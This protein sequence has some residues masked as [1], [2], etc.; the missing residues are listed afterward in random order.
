M[1]SCRSSIRA[2]PGL[3]FC[4]IGFPAQ[5]SNGAGIS[6]RV[7]TDAPAGHEHLAAMRPMR[8]C[9]KPSPG[10]VTDGKPLPV[11]VFYWIP[12]FETVQETLAGLAV[13][14]GSCFRRN[15]EYWVF[16]QSLKSHFRLFF[17]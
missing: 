12:A 1:K 5:T 11:W 10:Y 8:L 4:S 7:A 6:T 17:A 16:A 9:N 2:L 3:F 13:L 15:D 14:L